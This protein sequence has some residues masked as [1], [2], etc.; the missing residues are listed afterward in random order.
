MIPYRMAPTDVKGVGGTARLEPM[1][2]K[3]DL[4]KV[5]C[6]DSVHISYSRHRLPC[7]VPSMRRLDCRV[8]QT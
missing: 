7:I 2:F 1:G 5:G 8:V 3:F 4:L 6:H